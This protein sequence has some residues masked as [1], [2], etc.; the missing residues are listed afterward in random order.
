MRFGIIKEFKNT[1]KYEWLN[2]SLNSGNVV[3]SHKI[4]KLKSHQIYSNDINDKKGKNL[5]KAI[6]TISKIDNEDCFVL[7]E[8]VHGKYENSKYLKQ[9]L[10]LNQFFQTG[11]Y[12]HDQVKE[13]DFEDSIYNLGEEIDRPLYF[14]HR[15]VIKLSEEQEAILQKNFDAGFYILSGIAG[16]GKTSVAYLKLK[17]LSK[18]GHKC[19]F[20]TGNSHLADHLKKMSI[21]ENL[22]ENIEFLGYQD[23]MDSYYSNVSDL[24]K[25]GFEE[26]VSYIGSKKIAKSGLS[27]EMLY[28]VIQYIAANPDITPGKRQFYQEI[29]E[30]D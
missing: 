5:L 14:S 12:I 17:E 16:S 11:E 9:K 24:E 28:S 13:S 7:L 20:T 18:N 26:F 22:G 25:V 4:K 23:L 6:W 19:L 27:P 15:K 1:E 3:F 2:K 8:V 21:E 29:K 30:K 10:I